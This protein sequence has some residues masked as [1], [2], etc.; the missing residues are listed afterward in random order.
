MWVVKSEDRDYNSCVN[1]LMEK[2]KKEFKGE[3]KILPM[4]YDAADISTFMDKLC[5]I[6]SSPLHINLINIPEK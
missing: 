1:Y 6:S 5:I 4:Y 2:V 3:V